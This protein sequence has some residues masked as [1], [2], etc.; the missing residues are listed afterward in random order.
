MMNKFF[1]CLVIC[2]FFIVCWVNSQVRAHM[3]NFGQVKMIAPVGDTVFEGLQK[4]VLQRQK[5]FGSS[6]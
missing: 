6:F 1:N 5:W 2:F 3:G 4:S